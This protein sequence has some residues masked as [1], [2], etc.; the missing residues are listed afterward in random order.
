[1]STAHRQTRPITWRL[2]TPQQTELSPLFQLPREP[3]ELIGAQRGAAD[4][5]HTSQTNMPMCSRSLIRIQ[6]GMVMARTL[7]L[8]ALSCL[9]TGAM[10]QARRTAQVDRE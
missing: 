3:M 4:I 10:A 9:R 2:L 6:T 1:M 5:T 7:P 8:L